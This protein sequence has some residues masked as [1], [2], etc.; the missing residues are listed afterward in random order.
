M[1]DA[2]INS[3]KKKMNPYPYQTQRRQ[4]M[5]ERER[6]VDLGGR[7]FTAAT[8]GKKKKRFLVTALYVLRT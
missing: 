8:A 6:D 2:V 1:I 7:G 4:K 5:C 3:L